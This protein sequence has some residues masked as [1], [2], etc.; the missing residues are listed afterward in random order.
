[1][2]SVDS[3]THRYIIWI[4][5]SSDEEE[6]GFEI[7]RP[8]TPE[9]MCILEKCYAYNQLDDPRYMKFGR[10]SAASLFMNP[11]RVS[12][13]GH[14]ELPLETANMLRGAEKYRYFFSRLVPYQ[15]RG[16]FRKYRLDF[17]NC[18]N[19]LDYPIDRVYY[20]Q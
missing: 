6:T 5:I 9:E 13:D 15:Y 1:M 2:A 10:M 7:T 20:F 17:K 4:K 3:M 19:A 12:Y 8:I 14:P 11:F 16:I 18:L